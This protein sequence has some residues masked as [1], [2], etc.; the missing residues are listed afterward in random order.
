[1]LIYLIQKSIYMNNILVTGSNGQLG[2]ELKKISVNYKNYNFFF[3]DLPDLDICNY[4]LLNNFIFVNDI[5]F[6]INCAAYTNVDK[7]ESEVDLAYSVNFKAVSNLINILTKFDS[8]LIHVSTD[9]VFDGSSKT[10]LNELALTSPL[11]VYGSSKL[12]GEKACLFND[13]NS[14]VIRTS[15]LYS[16]FGN[17]FVKTMRNLMKK[18][19]SLNVVDDQIGSPTYAADL[20]DTI[21]KIINHKNWIPGLYHYSNEGEITWFDFANLIKEGFGF[22]TQINGISSKEYP[23]IAKRPKYSLLDKTKI[24]EIYNIKVSDYKESL[25]KC[26]KI[27]QNEA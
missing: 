2:N 11:N 17:N 25:K 14:I 26:I 23:T 12:R 16:S 19:N 15:W 4:D 22:K 27:L 21:L 18:N 3:K 1:M 7:A 10:P 13:S 6:V 5:D 8:K 9:Y 24:K 20:A